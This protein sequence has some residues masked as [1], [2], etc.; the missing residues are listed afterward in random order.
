MVRLLLLEYF[1]PRRLD[2][3]IRRNRDLLSVY[4]H[5]PIGILLPAGKDLV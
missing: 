4:F 3:P 2:L 5:G 1:L